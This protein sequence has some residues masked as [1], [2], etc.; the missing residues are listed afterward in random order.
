MC[1]CVCDRERET[2]CVFVCKFTWNRNV[3]VLWLRLCKVKDE[4]PSRFD[5]DLNPVILY[6]DVPKCIIRWGDVVKLHLLTDLL[7][8]SHILYGYIII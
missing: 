4:T 5:R 8:H 2:V 1:V 6:R 3:A 7:T